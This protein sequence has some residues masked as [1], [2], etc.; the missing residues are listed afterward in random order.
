MDAESHGWAWAQ[1]HGG[2]RARNW[3]RT[4]GAFASYV[5]AQRFLVLETK[6]YLTAVAVKEAQA[7]AAANKCPPNR[8]RRFPRLA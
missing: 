4:D 8:G 7:A 6:P 5:P 1:E 2:A 3:L